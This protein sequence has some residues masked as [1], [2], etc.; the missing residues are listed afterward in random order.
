[1]SSLYIK[2]INIMSSVFNS[3]VNCAIRRKEIISLN[4]LLLNKCGICEE[5]D[6][7]RQTGRKTDRQSLIQRSFTPKKII[8]FLKAPVKTFEMLREI[9]YSYVTMQYDISKHF[10]M[11]KNE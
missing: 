8:I 11:C 3:C 7:Y 9:L 2:E 5:I 6:G 10:R 1:M 4:V